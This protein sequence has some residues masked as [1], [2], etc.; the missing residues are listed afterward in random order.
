MNE[1]C[2]DDSDSFV[3]CSLPPDPELITQGWELRFIADVRM[4]R[5][6]IDT[7]SE[8]GYEVRLEPV[9]TDDLKDECN[10]CK[11]IFQQ[12]KVLYTRKKQENLE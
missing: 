4:A 3:G 1:P 8:L 9:N 7:Y 12:F 11:A 5:D 6:A 2:Y 10:G